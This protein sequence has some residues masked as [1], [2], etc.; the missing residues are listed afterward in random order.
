[1]ATLT[2]TVDAGATPA[3]GTLP[4][5][6]ST[7]AR[8]GAIDALRGLVIVFML[9]DHVRETFYLHHQVP[10]PMVVAE[11]PPELFFSRMLA[12]VCA[13]VF[14]FLTGLS[15]FLYGSR[16]GDDRPACASAASGFLFKRGLFLVLLEVTV[17]NFA[18]TFQFPP[19]KVFLQV[20]WVIG[21]SMMA[22]ALLLWLPRRLLIAL[23]IVLVA[24]H[25]LLDSLHFPAGHVMHV[26]WAVLHD[27]GW[28]DVSEGLRLRTSYPLLPWIGVI[29]LGYAAGPWFGPAVS[30]GERQRR[31][32]VWGIGLL[33][34]FI[35]LRALNVYGDKPWA[36]GE[37]TLVTVMS[38][39]NITK[40]PPSLLFCAL[41]LGVGLLLL[42]AF[43]RHPGA[44]WL[45]PLVV[46]GAAPMFFYV[47]HLY[48]LKFLYLGAVAIWGTNHG[49]YFGFD[50]MGGVWLCTVLV[51]VALYP[52]VKAFAA[53]KARRRDLTWLKY[54]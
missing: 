1:M 14:V 32:L 2:R 34:G 43:D 7:T 19:A 4:T 51:A 47:L 9:L 48:V 27:R 17:I 46:F 3:A 44:A 40:Y 15:A 16:H 26:P 37:T 53:F 25:N 54:L 41:T 22:L 18:W 35:V 28:I 39:F 13:P 50:T 49:E 11:T 36:V 21:L 23:G 45:R 38:F 29:A 12:H 10:D 6:R 8:L 33:A 24:G 42:R 20:I 30:T 31:L 5:Q 52:V